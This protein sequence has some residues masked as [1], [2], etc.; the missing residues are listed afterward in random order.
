V[1]TAQKFVHI[2]KSN[3]VIRG[4][5]DGVDGTV[6]H[7]H[8]AS[9]SPDP[10]MKWLGGTFPSFFK[11][12]QSVEKP[13]SLPGTAVQDAL[14]GTQTLKIKNNETI[15]PGGYVLV[16][17]NPPDTSLSKE[18]IYPLKNMGESHSRMGVKYALMVHVI[19]SEKGVLTLDAPITWRLQQKWKPRLIKLPH[20]I[21][22]T[23]I[24]NLR[25]VTDWKDEFIHHKDDIHDSGWDHI[26]MYGVENG[27]VRNVTSISPSSSISLSWCKNCAVYD[28]QITGNRG[29]NG[30]HINGG[31]TR[32]LWMNLKGGEA[33]HTYSMNGF[34]SGNVF[35]MCFTSAP[36]S[37]DCHGCLCIQNLFDNIYG[38]VVQ[39][40][41]NNK[42]VPPAHAQGLV[43][44]NFQT[45]LENAYNGRAVTQ[46]LKTPMYPGIR[47]VGL[48]SLLG[49]PVFIEDENGVLHRKD[50]STPFGSVEKLNTSAGPEI[51]S[52]YQWQH[53]KRYGILLPV[54]S[55]KS[56]PEESEE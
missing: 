27:W 55:G 49:Y 2:R 51:S 44:Y 33:M 22:E 45:G 1:E 37:V 40:G 16:Q 20:L 9:R 24:E 29:H 7:D 23:G 8:T 43:L 39:N 34:C 15:Q 18:L 28:C 53:K 36:T 3:I 32:N 46:I 6:L 25:L 14:A 26:H 13:D 21:E 50:F 10:N 12:G 38:A 42:A 52:L 31:S 11:V 56:H 41:G 19:R 5:G 17:D 48:K 47:I 54:E 35:H 30:F 4:Y